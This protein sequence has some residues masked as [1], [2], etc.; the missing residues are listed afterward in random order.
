MAE[1]IEKS[2]VVNML[3]L[4]EKICKP[5]SESL[6]LDD[7]EKGCYKGKASA[8]NDVHSFI[9]SLPV[10]EIAQD[11][12]VEKEIEERANQVSCCDFCHAS[13]VE[14]RVRWCADQFRY[15]YNLKHKHK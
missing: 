2:V 4:L 8:Y 12:D 14:D 7:S 11:A 15:F 3:A 5:L 13:E 9:D 10:L 1:Y 6:A